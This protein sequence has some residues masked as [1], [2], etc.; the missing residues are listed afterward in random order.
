VKLTLTQKATRNR[1]RAIAREEARQPGWVASRTEA[2]EAADYRAEL[3]RL[4]KE[5]K[6]AHRS[7]VKRK[8]ARDA[9]YRVVVLSGGIETNRRKH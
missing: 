6:K 9:K 5:A 7:N 3:K 1:Q 2:Q 4:T 8:K